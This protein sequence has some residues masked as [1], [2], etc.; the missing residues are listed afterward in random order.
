MPASRAA[1]HRFHGCRQRLDQRRVVRRSDGMDH[2]SV[3]KLTPQAG[4]LGRDVGQHL[5]D[6]RLDGLE[7]FL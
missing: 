6:F 2:H 7:P 1:G 3:S 4:M 5:L